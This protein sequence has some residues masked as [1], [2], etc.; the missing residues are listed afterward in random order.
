MNI[1]VSIKKMKPW[2]NNKDWKGLESNYFTLCQTHAG[3]EM[4]ERIQSLDLNSYENS[5]SLALE[6]SVKKAQELSAQAIYFEYDIDNDWQSYFYLC[7]EYAPESDGDEDWACDWEEYIEGPTQS[8]I[9]SIFEENGFDGD[10]S[11]VSITSYLI[12]RT[13]AS[14]GRCVESFVQKNDLKKLPICIAFH[15]QDPIM[16]IIE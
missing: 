13:V 3:K 2:I 6:E 9:S 5:L 11:I 7:T 8:E 14:F 12:A 4:A 10:D 16:R 15:G 1:F